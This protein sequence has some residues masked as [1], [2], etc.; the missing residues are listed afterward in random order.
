M[1]RFKD[2]VD[3]KWSSNGDLC[4]GDSGDLDDT[5]NDFYGGFLQRL[6]TILSSSKYDWKT[7][8]FVGAD[9]KQFV[10]KPNTRETGAAIKQAVLAA[11]QQYDLLRG[12]E[13]IVDVFPVSE[14]MIAIVL[15]ISPPG[16][17][18]QLV[19]NYSYDMRQNKITPRNT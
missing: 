16:A 10:G 11:V 8:S 2:I 4:L 14:Q 18:G 6:N 1:A 12:E 13:F 19:L 5:E 7:Q 3:I 15:V 17:G 9:L